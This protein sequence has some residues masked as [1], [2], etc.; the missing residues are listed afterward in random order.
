MP[1]GGNTER[2]SLTMET[3]GKLY[4]IEDEKSPGPGTLVEGVLLTVKKSGKRILDQQLEAMR[5]KEHVSLS[6]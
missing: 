3:H 6:L 1:L 5:T 4:M 2:I